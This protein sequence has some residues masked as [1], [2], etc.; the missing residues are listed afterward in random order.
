MTVR[1]GIAGPGAIAISFANGLQLLDDAEVYAVGSRSA[2][3]AKNF[4]AKYR[5]SANY[6]SY[7]DLAND[8]A[9][10]AVYV[11]TPQSRHEQDTLM[12]LEAGKPVLCEKPFALS[13]A[14]AQ[15]MV[16]VARQRGVLLMEAMWSRFLPA[17]R[18]LAELLRNKAIGEPQ[19]VEADFGFHIPFDPN[20]R[21]YDPERGGGGL[22][23]LG[24]YPVQFTSLVLGT[25][26]SVAAQGRIG[27]SGVDEQ[28]AAVLGYP[29]GKLAVVKAAIAAKLSSTAR[30]AG[31]EGV[32][33][34]PAPMHRP[35]S[36]V[37]IRGTD[38]E[39]ID[40][41]WKGEGLRFQVE[42]FHRCLATGELESPVISHAETLSIMGTLDAIR[43][44]IGL[45]FSGE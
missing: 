24:V 41:S 27:T 33:E 5:A 40:S 18:I 6:G 35:T 10:D 13:R 31:T 16:D 22:L 9:V 15:R 29:G 25:P 1:W 36:L 45:R 23:D 14:Q 28:V 20:H 4:A 42:E 30:I 37:V 12:F 2:D 32:I 34:L 19:L 26:T 7:E 44:Q 43:S 21:L 3:R 11:A 38:V 8:P 39:E 17:Y